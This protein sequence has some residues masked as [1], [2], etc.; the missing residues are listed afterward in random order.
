MN[1]YMPFVP[2]S[3]RSG[4]NPP[5]SARQKRKRMGDFIWREHFVS[6]SSQTKIYIL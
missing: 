3:K 6:I 2:Q 5:H 1:A 4:S